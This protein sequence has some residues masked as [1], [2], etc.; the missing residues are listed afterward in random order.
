MTPIALGQ[1]WRR[2]RDAVIY[3][4]TDSLPKPVA[5]HLEG[6]QDVWAWAGTA[7]GLRRR[8]LSVRT[9]RRDYQLVQEK[10]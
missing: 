5:A 10:A 3:E 1:M 8:R 2:K 9:L 4:I 6:R 7:K